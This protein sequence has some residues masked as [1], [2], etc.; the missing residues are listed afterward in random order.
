MD[1]REKSGLSTAE[2]VVVIEIFEKS[3]FMLR[4]GKE[5]FM[6]NAIMYC[7]NE[8]SREQCNMAIAY[9]QANKPG[10][11]PLE[12]FMITYEYSSVWWGI[13]MTEIRINFL[14]HLINN[15]KS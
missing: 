14:K 1:C 11:S 8:F 12:R 6:C 10:K 2:K 15:L 13:G 4:A 7:M 9:L 3:I 5:Y